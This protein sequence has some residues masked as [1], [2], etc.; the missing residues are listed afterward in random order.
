MAQ[1]KDLPVEVRL[2]VY[3]LLV[4]PRPFAQIGEK[5]DNPIFTTHFIGH[6]AIANGVNGLLS[7]ARTCRA[8]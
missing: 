2:M 7:L 5:K 4:P 8:M 1:Y 6:V 3:D